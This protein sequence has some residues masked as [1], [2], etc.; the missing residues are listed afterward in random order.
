MFAFFF[1]LL[2]RTVVMPVAA[3]F[4]LKNSVGLDYEVAFVGVCIVYSLLTIPL[5]I[6]HLLKVVPNLALIRLKRS[7][8]LVAEV[9]IE[10]LSL[11]G[12]WAAFMLTFHA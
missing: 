6:W 8:R 7:L 9:V 12:L 5:A 11:A 2:I 3:I 10:V 1:F 4:F